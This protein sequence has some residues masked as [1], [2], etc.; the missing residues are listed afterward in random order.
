MQILFEAAQPYIGTIAEAL[1]GILALLVIGAL[2]K[3]KAKVESWLEANTSAKQ[4]DLLHKVAQEAYSFVEREFTQAGGQAK[5]D[6]AV[7]RVI[8]R[9]NLDKMGLDAEDVRAAVQKAWIEL[10][11]KNRI[12]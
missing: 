4:R 5:L 11:K 2:Y 10:D 9:L 12:P 1:V 3:L 8:Q 6:A 7:D